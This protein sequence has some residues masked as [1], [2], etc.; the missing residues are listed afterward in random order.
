MVQHKPFSQACEENKLP[1]LQVLRGYLGNARTVLEIGSGSGQHAVFFAAA[2]PHLVWQA[3]DVAGYLPG[4]R[5][6]IEEAGLPNLP[7][8]IPL[9]VIQGPWPE[10]RFDA[11]FSA[12]TAH[13]M[14]ETKVAAMLRGLSM[15]LAA[16]GL[17]ALY[18]PFNY[19]GRYTSESN[20]RF[21]TWLKAQD[22]RSSIRDFEWLDELARDG[23]LT[24]VADHEM[25][26]NN[27]TLVW[28]LEA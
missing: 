18:G 1:I 21:D 3:S 6:W 25:P 20:A 26:V 9:E 5:A 24:L 8:P 22:P 16:G 23:G 17:F 13:I 4:I 28:R 11:V 2:F 19:G 14:S 27:R 7:P 12:N 15:V 10:T